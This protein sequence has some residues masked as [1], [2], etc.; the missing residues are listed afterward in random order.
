MLKTLCLR[1]DPV[2]T[3]CE[4]IQV[5]TSNFCKMKGLTWF[6]VFLLVSQLQRFMHKSVHHKKRLKNLT[7]QLEEK[8]TPLLYFQSFLFCLSHNYN[9]VITMSI[10]FWENS[11]VM[12]IL[13]LKCVSIYINAIHTLK[14]RFLLKLYYIEI[15]H[16]KNYKL[17]FLDL[18]PWIHYLSLCINCIKTSLRYQIQKLPL[19]TS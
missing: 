12:N 9:Y 18:S 5:A 6:H 15:N 8:K 7:F 16:T 3:L 4:R 19:T 14:R 1:K 2:I 11:A 10:I 17:Y 13:T